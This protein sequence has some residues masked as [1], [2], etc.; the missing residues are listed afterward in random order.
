VHPLPQQ[1]VAQRETV[2]VHNQSLQATSNV[3]FPEA[4]LS[5]LLPGN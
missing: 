2:L 5:L 3:S 1:I 4:E